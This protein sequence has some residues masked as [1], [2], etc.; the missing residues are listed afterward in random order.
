MYNTNFM[1]GIIFVFKKSNPIATEFPRPP[2]SD[3]YYCNK[4][5]FSQILEST[6]DIVTVF[7][8]TIQQ[9]F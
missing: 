4:F 3:I 1:I 2:A 9:N 8:E 7:L 6:P 5:L